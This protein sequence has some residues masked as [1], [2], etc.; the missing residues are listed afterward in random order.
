[1]HRFKSHRTKARQQAYQLRLRSAASCR[2]FYGPTSGMT[3]IDAAHAAAGDHTQDHVAG[4]RR[5]VASRGVGL[6]R[7]FI[8]RAE[9]GS[10]V[11]SCLFLRAILPLGR[12]ERNE[13]G[14]SR[15]RSACCS[16]RCVAFPAQGTFF[17]RASATRLSRPFAAATLSAA[18]TA[19]IAHTTACLAR[20]S[21]SLA[22]RA[23]PKGLASVRPRPRAGRTD[24][25]RPG[26]RSRGPNIQQNRASGD[27]HARNPNF[28]H[29]VH[30]VHRRS[31]F[32]I[33]K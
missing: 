21:A 3:G 12:A 33:G 30:A 11:W 1:M 17:P 4:H 20:S 32:C 29:S 9:A 13:K 10:V 14:D 6:G 2:R 24:P 19:R 31:R 26:V 16:R 23:Q 15:R 7:R 27:R 22:A 8:G 25:N 5:E 18:S 28:T